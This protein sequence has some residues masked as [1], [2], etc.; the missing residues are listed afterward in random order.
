MVKLNDELQEQIGKRWVHALNM[1]YF[2]NQS[3]Q[4]A[5]DFNVSYHT[6]NSWLQGQAPHI[7][8]LMIAWDKFGLSIINE[9]L[10][11]DFQITREDA[12]RELQD[13]QKKL[14]DTIEK[15]VATRAGGP[16]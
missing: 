11:P 13:L 5:R 9:T 2:T 8:Y 4:I 3:K 10:N 7:K 16:S 14:K 1:R 15:L 6:A 12:L